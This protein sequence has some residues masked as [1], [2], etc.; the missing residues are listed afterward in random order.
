M[1]FLHFILNL[2]LIFCASV[3]FAMAVQAPNRSLLITGTIGAVSY[4]PNIIAATLADDLYY[5]IVFGV[6]SVTT[7]CFFAARMYHIPAFILLVPGLVPYFPGQKMYQMIMSLF[8]QDV[9]QFI[10]NT[11]G[12]V[13]TSLCIYG[14]M[15]IV[16][17]ALPFI[18]SFFKKI[19]QKQAKNIAD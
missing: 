14:S 10:E 15:L 12:F 2:I 17:L 8:Q 6:A 11:S 18:V 5:G 19:K 9:D 4:I 13:E 3:G 1:S 7:L 16:N